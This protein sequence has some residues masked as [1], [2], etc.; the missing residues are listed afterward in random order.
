VWPWGHL[1]VAYLLYTAYARRWGDG[2]PHDIPALALAVGSQVPD[3]IDKPL[4]WS[5][6]V[7]PG[8]RT[9]GHSVFFAAVVLGTAYVVASRLHHAGTAIAFA[10]GYVAHLVTDL[11]PS[12]LTGNLGEASFLF[13]PVLEQPEYAD[14]GGLLEGFLRYS[15]APYEWAQLGLFAVA[16]VVWYRDRRPGVGYVRHHTG[17]VFRGEDSG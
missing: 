15:M 10:I 6:G 2:R 8:G 16:V 12:V 13:W 14:V 11:P 3:L 17:G 9:L 4:G 5:L 7:L 1:A